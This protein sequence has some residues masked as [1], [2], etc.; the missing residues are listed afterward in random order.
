M[1]KQIHYSGFWIRAVADFIDS[2]ILDCVSGLFL[3][4]LLGAV[5]WIKVLM[6]ASA[7]LAGISFFELFDP[8]VLQILFVVIRGGLS[9]VYYTYATFRFGTTLGKRPFRVYVVSQDSVNAVSFNQS[10]IRCLGY[11]VSYLPMGAGFLMAA[12]QPEKRAL[13]DLIAGTVSIIKKE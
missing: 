4:M 13:H 6:Q 7:S 11:F 9:L 3:L 1:D 8:F 12:F 5:Y 10:M 2:L